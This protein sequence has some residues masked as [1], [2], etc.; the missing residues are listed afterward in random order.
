MANPLLRLPEAL[1]SSQSDQMGPQVPH[2]P[3]WL[4]GRFSIDLRSPKIMGIVNLTP[5]SFSDGG[6]YLE[7]SKALAH[8]EQLL[9]EGAD[10]LD[11]GAESSRP[12]AI[13][14]SDQEE[15]ARLETV[16]KELVKWNCPI[17]IDTYRPETMRRAL[18][19]GADIINDIWALRQDGAIE[20]VAQSN[21]G[22]CLM[23]M[24]GDPQ[25]MQVTPIEKGVVPKVKLFFQNVSQ[26]L[27]EF[28]IDSK[29]WLIDPG[30][31]FGKS[32]SQNLVL[33]AQQKELMAL[34]QAMLV[35]WSR[36]STLGHVTGLEPK[37]RLIPSVTAALM[38]VDRGASVVRVHDVYE[39]RQALQIWAAVNNEK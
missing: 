18:E 13:P 30:I 9:K 35:G 21:C 1:G 39:T 20:A 28:E 27:Q 26:R 14:I 6:S 32:V 22:L 5:D 12:G 33:L 38:A 2:F 17:S 24:Q 34:G 8:A 7:P 16:L 10:I 25:T 3:F 37:R 19:V 29:R 11:I 15:W 23:H 36:K 4:A 31:G